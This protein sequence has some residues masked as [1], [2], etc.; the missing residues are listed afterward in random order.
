[1]GELSKL[2]NIGPYLEEQLN[3][4]G[5][6]SYEDLK[7]TGAKKAWLNIKSIDQSA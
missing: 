7:Q 3:M 2:I 1:M 5:I 6:F 4:I